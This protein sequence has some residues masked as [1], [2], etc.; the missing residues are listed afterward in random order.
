MKAICII[1]LFIFIF[2]IMPGVSAKEMPIP[3]FTTSDCACPELG[4]LIKSNFSSYG[5]DLSCVYQKSYQEDDYYDTLSLYITSWYEPE[6]AA[7]AFEIYRNYNYPEEKEGYG[8]D[9]HVVEDINE[10]DKISFI[11]RAGNASYRI[12]RK[13]HPID[14]T[15]IEISGNYNKYRADK[16]QEPIDDEVVAWADALEECGRRILGGQD[17]SSEKV[18]G[19][20]SVLGFPLKH[21]TIYVNPEEKTTTNDKGEFTLSVANKEHYDI[22]VEFQYEKDNHIFYR[23][24]MDKEPIKLKIEV[25]NN[26][27]SS[28]NFDVGLAT[29][30]VDDVNQDITKEIILDK[31]IQDKDLLLIPVNY[32][33]MQE[34]LEYYT[35]VLKVD[36]SKNT[37]D[38]F[39]YTGSKSAYNFE[40]GKQWINL[41]PEKSSYEDNYRPFTI[42]HE[43][44]HYVQHT[45]VGTESFASYLDEKNINHGG[46]ANEK[47]SDSFS[48]GLA[49]FMAT[50]IANHNKRYWADEESN[51]SSLY[52]YFGSLEPDIL[53]WEYR[54]QGEEQAIAGVLWDLVDGEEEAKKD[55]AADK[56]VIQ[57]LMEENF[58]KY[59]FN[60]DNSWD[61]SEFMHSLIDS[62]EY[63]GNFDNYFEERELRTLS[64]SFAENESEEFLKKILAYGK[65]EQGS[66]TQEEMHNFIKDN[67]D[68]FEKELKEDLGEDYKNL[69]KKITQN[70]IMEKITSSPDDDN[71]DMKTEEVWNLIKKSNFSLPL[72]DLKNA[73]N[74]LTSHGIYVETSVGDNNYTFGEPYLNT[75]KNKRRD[76]GEPFIDLGV[77]HY[78]SPEKIGIASNYERPN[79]KSSAQ[80]EGQYIQTNKEIPFYDIEYIVSTKD[81]FG[82]KVPTM[83]YKMRA[84]NEDG[85]VYV[86]L[87]RNAI[88]KVVPEGVTTEEPL[89]FSSENF[90]ADYEESVDKGYFIENEFSYTGKPPVYKN[91]LGKNSSNVL[92]YLGILV[93][94]IIIVGIVVL[95]RKKKKK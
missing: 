26:E 68:F 51:S 12:G 74:I 2:L 85:L 18:K 75:N 17:L 29:Y 20:I 4:W 82:L 60:K 38:L 41:D 8:K 72:K 36:L 69:P 14:T 70:M 50:I 45:L 40:N 92:L 84:R 49:A 48:E 33:H 16:N 79:R 93:G 39:I 61:H 89:V 13:V 10:K 27:I 91:T 6:D 21:A 64:E 63:N 7:E 22:T 37:V 90:I 25:N 15:L 23:V 67:L 58:K 94:V 42:Y 59:D 11:Y 55:G 5:L 73:D 76:A 1:I 34:A 30:A 44:T 35:D 95:S 9:Q 81:Y 78:D 65:T 86:P 32:L 28:M 62:E 46:Y 87:P 83:I 3:H 19:K 31:L 77:M 52:P 88:V 53:A 24:M 66:L 56:A 57:R 47:S 43:F 54:G 71:V 80:L